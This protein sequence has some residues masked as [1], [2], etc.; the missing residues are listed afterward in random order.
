MDYSTARSIAVKNGYIVTPIAPNSK[1]PV[2]TDWRNERNYSPRGY[3]GYGMGIL[4][5]IGKLP[6]S[7]IDIDVTDEVICNQ[8]RDYVL[9]ECGE[10]IY[11]IGKA[12]KVLL[13]YR[14]Y[15][16]GIKKI[17]S[18]KYA[19]GRIEVLG[20]G[21]QF[22]ALGIHPDTKQPYTWPNMLGSILDVAADS[23]PV[24]EEKHLK[25]LL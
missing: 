21:Q 14:A 24:L 22:I 15:R 1:A 8:M 17:T 7:A 2:L 9:S 19:I 13:V 16:P 20:D 23:L 6:I 11:R 3:S 5:G 4:C 12:P 25:R 18:K 10:T